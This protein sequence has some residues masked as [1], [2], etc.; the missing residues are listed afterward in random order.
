MLIIDAVYAPGMAGSLRN[1]DLNLLPTLD[2]L[3]RERN[4]TRTAEQL[5]LSQPAVSA[6]LGRLRRHFGDELLHR[7]GNRYELTPLAQQLR[8]R[9][10]PAL[11]GV[12]RVFDASPEFDPAT[13]DREFSLM[14]SDYAMA[15]Y[16]ELLVRRL[17]DEAP[18]VRLRME[19]T[20]PH[21]VDQ[22]LELLRAIDGLIIPHG[23]L[24]DIPVTDLYDDTWVC[25]VSADNDAVG[26]ALTMDQVATAQWVVMWD[27]PTAFAPAARQ[28]SMLGVEPRVAIAVDS[29]LAVPFL[30][31][32]TERIAVLQGRLADRLAGTA[33][34]RALPCPWDVVPLKEALWWH[35][36]HRVD[37]A[38]RWLRSVMRQ[39]GADLQE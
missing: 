5:G 13:A 24:S 33:G 35:P 25:I 16:G 28:L 19:K 38:H 18:G 15:V 10:E 2:A 31:A 6:A 32:G 26:D 12:Q 17:A 7:T 8:G 27:L 20:D 23:F 34:V 29:F 37:P 14:I 3:L 9:T 39:V 11:Q 1:L 21:L 4:V 30:I 22:P 36:S